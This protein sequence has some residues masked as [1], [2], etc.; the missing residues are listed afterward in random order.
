MKFKCLFCKVP[1]KSSQICIML[2]APHVDTYNLFDAVVKSF[3]ANIK[4]AR[5]IC[6]HF[7]L[8]PKRFV[9]PTNAPLKLNLNFLLHEL[10]HISLLIYS[11]ANVTRFCLSF[12]LC[13]AC[14]DMNISFA[15]EMWHSHIMRVYNFSFLLITLMAHETAASQMS[16][17][18]DDKSV[19][20]FGVQLPPA[21]KFITFLKSSQVVSDKEWWS[22]S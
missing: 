4:S 11:G 22:R 5:E 8:L 3:I 13:V 6:F 1:W 14:R 15:V 17:R 19:R 16:E 7:K 9:L 2:H 12:F 10:W 20:F 21:I 18:R